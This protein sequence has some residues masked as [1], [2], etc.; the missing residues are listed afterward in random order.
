MIVEFRNIKI[1]HP[2]RLRVELGLILKNTFEFSNRYFRV[3]DQEKYSHRLLLNSA[4]VLL[5][6]HFEMIFLRNFHLFLC[7]FSTVGG[8]HDRSDLQF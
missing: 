5:R 1:K 6:D 8:N 2:E 7:F 4:Q 3:Q